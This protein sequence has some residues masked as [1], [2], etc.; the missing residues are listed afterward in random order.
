[1][2]GTY[3][4]L[5]KSHFEDC[6]V[7]VICKPGSPENRPKLLEPRHLVPRKNKIMKSLYCGRC[8]Y[9][10][11]SDFVFVV[12]F[13]LRLVTPSVLNSLLFLYVTF[14]PK[15]YCFS[16]IYSLTKINKS[17]KKQRNMSTVDC[18]GV[19]NVFV[20]CVVLL[21]SILMKHFFFP[22]NLTENSLSTYD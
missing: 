13:F 7:T 6:G 4:T 15:S 16:C 12:S 3:Y 21:S 1:M 22:F 11:L 2:Q 5:K 10:V 18:S 8:E 19:N 14:L 20:F 9:Y 17:I